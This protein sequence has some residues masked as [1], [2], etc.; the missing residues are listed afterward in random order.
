VGPGYQVP[1]AGAV[2]VR[3]GVRTAAVGL[4]TEPRQ[5]Q[6]ILDEGAADAVFLGRAALREPAWPVR[7]AHEL[8]VAVRDAPYPVQYLRGAYRS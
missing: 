6:E 5:A 3:T 8:G 7:A 2:R 1:F 4:I